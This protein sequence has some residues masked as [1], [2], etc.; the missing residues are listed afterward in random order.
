VK[1]LEQVV[2]NTNV[3]SDV[4]L[5]LANAE[6]SRLR[7]AL[8]SSKA[9]LSQLRDALTAAIGD[10]EEALTTADPNSRVILDQTV[11]QLRQEEDSGRTPE[12]PPPGS[13]AAIES[14]QD[15]GAQAASHAGMPQSRECGE[16]TLDSGALSKPLFQHL[17][18]QSLHDDGVDTLTMAGADLAATGNGYSSMGQMAMATAA[19][20]TFPAQHGQQGQQWLGTASLPLDLSQHQTL[21]PADSPNGSLDLVTTGLSFPPGV[22]NYPSVFSAHL[23]II[24]L[25]AKKNPA[26]ENRVTN[27]APFAKLVSTMVNMFVHTCWPEMSLWWTYIQSAAV[28]EK[29]IRWS[30]DASLENYKTLPVTHRPTA[31][32]TCTAHPPIIDWAF[33][34]TIRDRLIELYSHSWVLDDIVCKLVHSYVVEAE[35]THVV[36]GLEGMPSQIGYFRVWDIVRTIS[37]ESKAQSNFWTDLDNDTFGETADPFELDLTGTSHSWT[38]VPLEKIYRSR[39]AAWKLF[40]LLRMEDRR[41]I[42]LDPAFATAHPELCDEPSIIASGLDCTLQGDSMSV[43]RPKPLTREAI[44]NY[45]MMLWKATM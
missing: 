17:I 27:P 10:L 13:S 22:I 41:A 31:L 28:V 43:P 40:K 2:G 33:F 6:A 36:T 12:F 23:S 16:P 34:P 19:Q 29:L 9:R 11:A 3:R 4:A 8:R 15:S 7:E 21:F 18:N 38:K 44:I 20:I 14:N 5:E 42:K 25:F 32:Q 30:L 45:K 24:D 1:D 26:Y 37:A 35:L 39:E